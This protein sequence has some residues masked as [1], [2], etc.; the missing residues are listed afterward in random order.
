[1]RTQPWEAALPSDAVSDVPWMPAPSK[2][3]I[4]RA[5]IGLSGPGGIVVAGELAGPVAVR[6]VP[7]GFDR[8]VLDV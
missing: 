3:P 6:D 8:L 5:L 1:M 2:M 7:V 4:Q